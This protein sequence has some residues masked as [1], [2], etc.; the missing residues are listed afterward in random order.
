MFSKAL[1]GTHVFS[2][3]PFLAL[4]DYKLYPVTFGQ[5]AEARRL[6]G[7][8][9][10][11]DVATLILGDES[12][13]LLVV[14]PFD[15]SGFRFLLGHF[16]SISFFKTVFY[17][18]AYIST[19]GTKKTTQTSQVWVVYVRVPKQS[20][21]HL[22]MINITSFPGAVKRVHAKKDKALASRV[23]RNIL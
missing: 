9:M 22:L 6:D 4:D 8:E 14:E 5:T 1:D 11:K 2:R 12:I 18:V 23:G 7:A 15:G 17:N 19:L 21:L 13:A 10:H 3:G 20:L 16:F